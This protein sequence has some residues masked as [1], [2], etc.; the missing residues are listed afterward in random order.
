MQRQK[1][2]VDLDGEAELAQHR[3]QAWAVAGRD[4]LE[5]N[6]PA[7]RPSIGRSS[8]ACSKMHR[9]LGSHS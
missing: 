7:V 6:L 2:V 8:S 5:L 3:W 9:L 1:Q 4:L